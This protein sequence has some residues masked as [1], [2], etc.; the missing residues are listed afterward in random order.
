MEYIE[1][2]KKDYEKVYFNT[3]NYK[4]FFEKC[5]KNYSDFLSHYFVREGGVLSGFLFRYVGGF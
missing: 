3:N 5:S 2:D 1:Y 4:N